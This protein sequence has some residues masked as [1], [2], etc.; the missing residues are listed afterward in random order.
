MEYVIPI[1]AGIALSAATG[2]RIFMPFFVLSLAALGGYV[3]LAPGFA[4]LATPPAVI[5]LGV[6]SVLEI[7]AYFI[8]WVDNLLDGIATPA[9]AIAGTLAAASLFGDMSPMLQWSLAVI[10]GG[11]VATAVQAS[12]VVARG[13]ST[14]FTGGLGNFLVAT[15]EL[16]SATAITLLALLAPVL[17]LVLVMALLFWI[18][19]R[20]TARRRARPQAG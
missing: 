13:A 16:V 12:T 11:G 18:G 17:A 8:P 19:G 14:L 9:A 7:G 3:D 10:A 15:L 1:A 5:M 6:A 2:F 20:L 4:W